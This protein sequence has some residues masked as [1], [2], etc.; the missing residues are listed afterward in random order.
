[1]WRSEAL[2]RAV[3]EVEVSLAAAWDA[4]LRQRGVEPG[5]ATEQELSS[6][7]ADDPA[8]HDWPVYDAALLRLICAECGSPLAAGPPS[9][10]QCELH[11]GLR[12]GAQETDRA[13]VPPGNEHAVRVASA[14][15]R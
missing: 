9:C 6:A 3:T 8:G 12:F 15:A 13:G 10:P 4:L 7:V 2:A 14:V 5:T 11:V 1:M